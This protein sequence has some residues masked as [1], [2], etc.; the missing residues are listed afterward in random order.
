MR[1]YT[2]AAVTPPKRSIDQRAHSVSLYLRGMPV[3]TSTVKLT[4]TRKCI[5]RWKT[6][7]RRYSMRV[8]TF[9]R[10]LLF[11]G[12]ASAVEAILEPPVDVQA[13]MRGAEREDHGDEHDVGRVER[14]D[15]ERRA[16]TGGIHVDHESDEVLVGF[17]VALGACLDQIGLVDRALRVGRSEDPVTAVA[18]GADGGLRVPEVERL[19][20]VAVEVRLERVGVAAR[21]QRVDGSAE[22]R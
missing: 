5:Q 12:T 9:L 17:G 20:V 10:A 18:V 22:G 8:R 4:K 21:A 11:V 1:W 13:R 3:N 2:P 14:P 15:Q 16:R 19:A 6:L 7:N